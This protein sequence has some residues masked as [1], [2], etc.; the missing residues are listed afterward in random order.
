MHSRAGGLLGSGWLG[1]YEAWQCVRDGGIVVSTYTSRNTRRC[2]YL[3]MHARSP[4]L[5]PAV[6]FLLRPGAPEW[7]GEARGL[8]RRLSGDLCTLTWDSD[9]GPVDRLRALH[10]S[11][12]LGGEIG[13]ELG[14]GWGGDCVTWAFLW[15][16]TPLEKGSDQPV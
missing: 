11:F 16:Q 14:E 1:V 6:L 7:L 3:C 8:Q 10:V 12:G 2:V 4:S 15:L 5:L 9:L 13:A